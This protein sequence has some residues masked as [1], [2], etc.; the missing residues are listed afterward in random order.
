MKTL[1]PVLC[2]YVRRWQF[3]LVLGLWLSQFV[4]FV[5]FACSGRHLSGYAFGA[6]AFG[7]FTFAVI[8]VAAAVAVQTKEHLGAYRAALVPGYMRPHLAAAGLWLAVALLPFPAV[9]LATGHPASGL[10]G[11][12]LALAGLAFAGCCRGGWRAGVLFGGCLL[13]CLPPVGKAVGAVAAGTA[14]WAAVSLGLLGLW[15]LADAV[16]F[17]VTMDEETPGYDVQWRGNL[18]QL[19]GPQARRG[20]FAAIRRLDRQNSLWLR[21]VDVRMPAVIPFLGDSR[22]QRIRHWRRAQP[23]SALVV[24]TG[25]LTW[26]FMFAV[27]YGVGDG[28]VSPSIVLRNTLWIL[29][30]M[31]PMAAMQSWQ[32][33][34]GM[35]A[36]ELTYPVR[37]RDLILEQGAAIL[38]TVLLAWLLLVVTIMLLVSLLPGVVPWG[39][40]TTAVLLSG[41]WQL[42]VVALL[43]RLATLNSAVP[44]V[45][46]LTLGAA[47][48]TAILFGCLALDSL[49]AAVGV[50]GAITV[51]GLLTVRS[52][53]R[54]WLRADIA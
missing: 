24:V 46:V 32:T 49:P 13:F 39:T 27:Q 43:A 35:V 33:R 53:Y 1:W 25:S 52:C 17:L 40:I 23:N 2:S 36:R 42:L 47:V 18:R 51:V 44:M 14:P 7:A 12:G 4:P 37:R 21:L 48:G 30:M 38:L 28:H 15:F 54:H 31:P 26:L 11:L 3:W 19:S 45:A 34:G 29:V 10:L 9:A 8:Y 20:M 50:G 22:W 6:Y 16:L 41:P 5:C